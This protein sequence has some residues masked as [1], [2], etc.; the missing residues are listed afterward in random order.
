MLKLWMAALGA[1]SKYPKMTINELFTADK[2][3][4]TKVL[5]QGTEAKSIALRIKAG[6]E[7]KEHISKTD[8]LLLCISGKAVY[9]DE[10][11]ETLMNAGDYVAIT[12]NVKHRVEAIVQSDFLLMK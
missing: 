9:H 6:E 10:S 7:L 4:Q 11:G 1:T 3:V 8:A 12:Q 5:F 2:A